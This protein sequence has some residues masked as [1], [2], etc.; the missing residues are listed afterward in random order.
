M[1]K[2]RVT[3]ALALLVTGALTSRAGR[4]AADRLTLGDIEAR[5]QRER[6]ELAE[7][8]ASIDRANAELAAV[9]AKTRPTLGA[10]GDLSISPGGQLIRYNYQGEDYFV[11]GAPAL[12]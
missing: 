3:W 12:G 10:R 11:Q 1:I 2:G 4:A 6:P 5:A 9:R 8:R 7:R